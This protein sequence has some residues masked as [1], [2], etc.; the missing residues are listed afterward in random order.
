MILSMATRNAANVFPDPVGANSSVWCPLAMRGQALACTAVGLSNA[1]TNHSR[2][3]G[4]KCLSG[5]SFARD[6]ISDIKPI[7]AAPSDQPPWAAPVCRRSP[8]VAAPVAHAADVINGAARR[9]DP[10]RRLEIVAEF[11][12]IRAEPQ[13]PA[14]L[15]EGRTMNIRGEGRKPLVRAAVNTNTRRT[16]RTKIWS[17]IIR[18]CSRFATGSSI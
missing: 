6:A 5:P 1:S 12:R 15:H 10:S 3:G 2:R 14:N 13:A 7:S 9:S 8:V 18:G 4:W 16:R 11:A 17:G